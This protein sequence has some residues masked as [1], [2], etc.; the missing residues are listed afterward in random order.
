MITHHLTSYLLAALLLLIG[1]CQ[2]VTGERRSAR[3]ALGTGTLVASASIGWVVLTG[4]PVL[5]YLSYFPKTALASIGPIAR[6]LLGERPDVTAGVTAATQTRALF[7]G[8]TLPLYEHYAA[9][10]VQVIAAVA[11]VLAAWRLRRSRSGALLALSLLAA[12]YFVLLPLR[13]NA[14]GEAGAGRISTFQWIG[15]AVVVATGLVARPWRNPAGCHSLAGWDRFVWSSKRVWQATTACATIAVLFVSLVGS[16]GSAVDPALRF[17]GAF[18]LN[19]SD[20]RDTTSEAVGLAQRF[21]AA[22][23]PGQRVVVSDDA[24]ERVFETYAFVPDLGPFPQ[25]AFFLPTYTSQQLRHLASAGHISAIVI[26]TRITEDGGTA[27]ALPGY[28]PAVLPPI[29]AAGLS[30]LSSF[31]WLKVAFRTAHYV[32]LRV[33]G[34]SYVP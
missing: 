1:L 12:G 11:M 4:V 26:D 14:A 18:E 8:S 20:G 22:E 30:R 16:Y 31:S 10:A 24:T 15:I 32:V 7:T 21:L 33:V 28:P 9:Y 17:P 6:Q 27:A 34:N 25:W 29:T 13:L 3:S 2:L 23:G 5:P 19:S